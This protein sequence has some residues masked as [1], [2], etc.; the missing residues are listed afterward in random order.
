MAISCELKDLGLLVEPGK[1]TVSEFLARWLTTS[2]EVEGIR[3][4]A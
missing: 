1:E 3:A 2:C 4:H